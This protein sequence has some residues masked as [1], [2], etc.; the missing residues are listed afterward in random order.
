MCQSKAIRLSQNFIF[1]SI[2]IRW[3]FNKYLTCSQDNQK[4]SSLLYKFILQMVRHWLWDFRERASKCVFIT[5]WNEETKFSSLWCKEM[6]KWWYWME[7]CNI[8]RASPAST[9][10]SSDTTVWHDTILHTLTNLWGPP[11]PAQGRRHNTSTHQTCKFY[12]T[13]RYRCSHSNLQIESNSQHY[14]RVWDL[15]ADEE[16]LWLVWCLDL[17][18]FGVPALST[19]QIGEGRAQTRSTR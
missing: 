19:R 4:V 15:S 13:D 11:Q 10:T 16:F 14:I 1:Y 2:P 3:H 5:N 6:C 17:S 9:D 12:W 18:G 7:D 8:T